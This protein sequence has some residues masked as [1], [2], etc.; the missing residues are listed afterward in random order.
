MNTILK[1]ECG[2]DVRRTLIH[3]TPTF[4]SIDHAVRELCPGFGADGAKYV[5][6]DGDACTLKE[7]TF[8]DFL[9]TTEETAHGNALRLRLLSMPADA[10]TSTPTGGARSAGRGQLRGEADASAGAELAMD[11][12][13]AEKIDLV[14]AAFDQNGDGHLNFEE[15]S[16]LHNAADGAELS[17]S[18]YAMMCKDEGEDPELGLGREALMCVYNRCRNLEIDFNAAKGTLQGI[19]WIESSDSERLRRE[20]AADWAAWR[21]INAQTDDAA[22]Y[23]IGTP[24]N[25]PRGE[26]FRR[27]LGASQAKPV[28]PP[29]ADSAS[30]SRRDVVQEHEHDEK[31]DIVLAAFDENGDEHLNYAE[32]NALHV[33]AWGDELSPELYSKMCV[34]EGE[35]PEVGLG[36]EALMCIY[37]RCR[38]LQ[39][40]FDAAKGKLEGVTMMEETTQR[41][42]DKAHPINMLLKNPQLAL[43]FAMDAAERLRQGMAGK[44][45]RV[46]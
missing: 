42:V 26:V 33:A 10:S 28:D 25:S 9:M 37:N 18:V 27:E 8:A 14:L 43:P 2:D 12:E 5:D 31:I 11:H 30:S 20:V 29:L 34:L 38:K 13:T 19:T 3:G 32:I 39:T 15:M 4:A 45:T 1:V 6:E 35:D 23:P 40:D 17:A 7:Q 16:L 41:P 46:Q 36:R 44:F 24:T 21:S 22:G